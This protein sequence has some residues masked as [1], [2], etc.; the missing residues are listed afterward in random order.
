MASPI[1]TGDIARL[2]QEGVQ[3]VFG[4]AYDKWEKQYPLIFDEFKSSKNYELDVQLEG[5]GLA[6][7]KTEGNSSA[8]DSFRQGFTPKYPN[9]NY[10]LGFIISEEALEDELY[11]EMEKK[12]RSLGFSMS[13]TKEQVAADVLNNGHDTNYIMVDGDGLPLFSTAHVNGPSGGTFSNRLSVA[14]DLTEASLEDLTIQV[15]TATDPRGLQ[16]ALQVIRLIVHPNDQFEAQR[17]MGSVLQNDTAN[18]ATNALRD[19]KVITQGFAVNQYLTDTDA[20]FLKTSCPD[21]LKHFMRRAVRFQDDNEFTSNNMRMKAS[22]RYSFG[23]T[24]P[25]GC[26]SNG[27]GA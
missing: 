6:P 3:K 5:L 26:F 27:G 11:G 12:S 13:Q 22:E 8:F 9:L 21:G 17:I 19:S 14:A 7:V 25:R 18:N 2:L 15:R 20:F 23:W 10:S 1:L 16:I 24:D 4:D